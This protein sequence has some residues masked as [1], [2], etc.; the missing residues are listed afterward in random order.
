VLA[1]DLHV[2]LLD[3]HGVASPSAADLDRSPLE[4]AASSPRIAS[5]PAQSTPGVGRS[6]AAVKAHEER[7]WR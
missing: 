6:S 2:S 4:S 3:P 7:G 5:P 1:T